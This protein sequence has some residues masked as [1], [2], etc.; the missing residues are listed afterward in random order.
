M[1]A[2]VPPGANP[3]LYDAA[4]QHAFA[5][6]QAAV[7]A[8]ADLKA[9]PSNLEPPLADVR[10]EEDDFLLNGCMRLFR[11]VGHP[12]CATGDTTSTTTVAL[13][14]DSNAAMWNP[15]LQ[16]VATQRQWRLETLTKAGCPVLDLPIFERL[17]GREYTECEQW[18]GQII[19]RLRA[20]RPRLVVLSI[21]RRYE[22]DSGF[23]SYDPAWI[24]RMTRLT[25]EL[26]GI[27][28][29]VLV[30]GPIPD[31]GPDVPLCL[32]THLDEAT[33]CS[34]SRST[35]VNNP[36]IA[37]ETAAVKA[38]GGQ[39]ADLTDLFCTAHAARSSWATP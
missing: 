35:A 13:L 8:S 23:T 10:A 33:A 26:R 4:V 12:E 17:L 18:R 39:Y 25:R 24:D 16:Q 5:Q 27:G 11:E 3:D 36:G 34:P 20:E 29:Q 7:A 28:A 19:D 38:G 22:P 31:P 6:V 15:A 37:A 32:S 21:S 9:V 30:L 1:A 14:G 2:P